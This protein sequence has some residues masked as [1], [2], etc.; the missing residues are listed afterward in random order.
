MCD[1]R[2][3]GPARP[4]GPTGP[5][6]LAVG[7]L[8]QCGPNVFLQNIPCAHEYWGG[9]NGCPSKRNV[10]PQNRSGLHVRLLHRSRFFESNGVTGRYRVLGHNRG[11][12]CL[13]NGF[14]AGER[15]RPL[16]ILALRI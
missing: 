9:C 12:R 11:P 10:N 2:A 4:S 14:L 3:T 5:A 15:E 7:Y 1:L 8:V 6:G 16:T 13:S